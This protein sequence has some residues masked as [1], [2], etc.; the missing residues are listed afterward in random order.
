MD[1]TTIYLGVCAIFIANVVGVP[2]D[3]ARQLTVVITALLA[4]I[5]TAGVL[6]GGSYNALYGS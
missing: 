6:G 4:S 2:L 3:F 1:G 5:G